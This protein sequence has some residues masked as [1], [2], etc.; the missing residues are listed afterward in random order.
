MPHGQDILQPLRKCLLDFCVKWQGPSRIMAR[1]ITPSKEPLFEPAQVVDSSLQHFPSKSQSKHG[2]PMPINPFAC[3]RWRPCPSL[4][5]GVPT[6]YQND[7]P[8]SFSFWPSL[9]ANPEDVPLSIHFQNWRS[10]NVDASVTEQLLAEE[11]AQGFCFKYEG[12][13]E[14]AKREWPLGLAIGKL[15][16]VRAPGRSERLVLD[17]TVCGTNANCSVRERQCMPTVRD[18]K[19]SYPLR[20]TSCIQ[21]AMSLDIKSAHKRVVV[22]PSEVG[23]LG[24]NFD[25]CLYFYRVAP[26]GVVFAQHWW[27]RLGSLI[28]RLLHMLVWISHTGHL[29]VD[30]YLFS[31]L[32]ELMPLMGSMIC[33]F[34]QVF[35]VP[36]SLH[37]LQIGSKVQWLGWAFDFAAGTVS[38]TTQRRH[39]LLAMVQSLQRNPRVTKK[40]FERFVGLTRP[41][42]M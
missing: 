31:M 30:D 35:G 27:G 23:L 8:P 16:V 29:F 41:L 22:R 9:H 36:L 24:F 13:L 12:S 14:D 37:K 39:K 40:D 4:K 33:L 2:Y 18:V 38:L 34:M 17:N 25:N 1:A 42:G 32:S 15:G 6:G 11:L 3:M 10:A 26:F 20:G 7:I 5:S 21:S 19:S 28:L